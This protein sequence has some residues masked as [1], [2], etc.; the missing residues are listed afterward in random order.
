LN[1]ISPQS[2]R[3][4]DDLDI[5]EHV[6][7]VINKVETS[8]TSGNERLKEIPNSFLG[9]KGKKIDLAF[10]YAFL[11]LDDKDLQFVSR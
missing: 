4:K 6:T 1:G 8:L 10:F 7:K 2:A 5:K 3:F 9:P 11:M